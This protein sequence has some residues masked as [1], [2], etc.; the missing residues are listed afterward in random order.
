MHAL[1]KQWETFRQHWYRV[2][3]SHWANLIANKN[4]WISLLAF[5]LTKFETRHN[6]R[7][8]IT[9]TFK[10]DLCWNVSADGMDSGLRSTDTETLV[11]RAVQRTRLYRLWSIL[12]CCFCFPADIPLLKEAWSLP[13][14]YQRQ[15]QSPSFSIS[16]C[17]PGL[18]VAVNPLPPTPLSSQRRKD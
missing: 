9:K 7:L 5:L 15:E 1:V 17:W 13:A 16:Y 8:Q 2:R 4:L 3:S 12:M 10:A 11:D 18:T 14:C 6:C